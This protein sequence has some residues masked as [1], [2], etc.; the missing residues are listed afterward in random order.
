MPCSSVFWLPLTRFSAPEMHIS[1]RLLVNSVARRMQL[2][3]LQVNVVPTR[4]PMLPACVTVT[5]QTPP[6]MAVKTRDPAFLVQCMQPVSILWHHIAPTM[7]LC[8]QIHDF[9]SILHLIDHFLLFLFWC[10]FCVQLVKIDYS[11]MRMVRIIWKV[12]WSL[13]SIFILFSV[14]F[15]WFSFENF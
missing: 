14:C 2:T 5:K 8:I 10:K 6:S 15:I 9:R 12:I 11:Y 7:H 13:F 3:L 4:D 1:S